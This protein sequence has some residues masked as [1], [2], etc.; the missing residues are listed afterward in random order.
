MACKTEAPMKEF[1]SKQAQFA[2]KYPTGWSFDTSRYAIVQDL[3][4]NND[5]FQE[6]V[7][8]GTEQLPLVTSMENYA[9]SFVST[10]K[11]LDS[12]YTELENKKVKVGD[13]DAVQIVFNTIQNNQKYKNALMLVVRDSTAFIIQG[14]ALNESYDACKSDFEKIFKSVNCSKP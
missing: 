4:G 3:Q 8:L 12:N 6:T 9:K 11:I 5:V 14:N 10:M 13:L 1:V 2:I 7:V